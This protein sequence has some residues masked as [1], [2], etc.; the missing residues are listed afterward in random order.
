MEEIT[1]IPPAEA[2]G[3]PGNEVI[4]ALPGVPIDEI[5]ATIAATDR[6]PLTKVSMVS[7]TGIPRQVF[8]RGERLRTG[9]GEVKGGHGAGAR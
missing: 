6:L 8:L 7:K 3:R 9:A 4:R 1:G 5:I 2:L